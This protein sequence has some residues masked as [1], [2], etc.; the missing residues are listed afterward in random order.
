[1]GPING[2]NKRKTRVVAKYSNSNIT[3]YSASGCDII[4]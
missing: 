4:E 2:E 1:M 3:I